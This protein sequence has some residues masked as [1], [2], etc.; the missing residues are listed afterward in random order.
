MEEKKLWQK[1]SETEGKQRE[2]RVTIESEIVYFVNET[3]PQVLRL[4]GRWRCWLRWLSGLRSWSKELALANQTV[5]G[6][7]DRG[8]NPGLR[9]MNRFNSYR[10]CQRSHDVV[11][12]TITCRARQTGFNPSSFQMFASPWV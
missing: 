10:Q 7:E 9:I 2:W 5:L 3:I 1:T 8:S 11:V 4:S 12:R 6:P